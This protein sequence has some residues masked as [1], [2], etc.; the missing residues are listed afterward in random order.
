MLT[1][2]EIL[3]DELWLNEENY[4][5]HDWKR[6]ISLIENYNNGDVDELQDQVNSL[7]CDVS[8]LEDERDELQDKVD[9][10]TD[11]LEEAKKEIE[12]LQA[13]QK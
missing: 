4:M 12:D 2:E 6:L 10:L 13:N 1:A 3:R 9:K 8:S 7:E 11:E 5:S